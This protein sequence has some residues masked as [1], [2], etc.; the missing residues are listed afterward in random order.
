MKKLST[1][2]LI[3]STTLLL[4][5]C[6]DSEE[7]QKLD[8]VSAIGIDKGTS[9]ENDRYHVSIQIIN[10]PQEAGGQQ[11]G[12]VQAAPVISYSDNGSTLSETLRKITR[13]TSGELFFP[14]V[15][16]LVISEEMAKEGIRDLFDLIERDSRFRV[17]FPVVIARRN[18]A[19]DVLKVM[20]S[21]KALPTEKITGSLETSKRV[22]GEVPSTRADQVI[23]RLNKGS[24]GITGIQINGDVEKGNQDINMKQVTPA[25]RIQVSGLALIKG[26]KL[27]KWM[28]KDPARGVTWAKNEVKGTVINLDCKKKRN[29]IAI[30]I[31]RSKSNIGVK[32]KN[33][34]PVIGIT[35]VTEGNVSETQCPIELEKNKVIEKLEAQ[36][37]KEIKSEVM[38]AVTISKK[39]KCDIFN[40]GE[41]VNIEDKKLWKIIKDKWED[42]ILPKT[43]VNVNVQAFIRRTGFRTKPYLK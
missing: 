37:K 30:D 21:L 13:K 33:N 38:K 12:K 15:Q 14:H 16:L 32:I 7:L 41:Y 18:R 25:A 3:L 9:N 28:D 39:Q 11:V 26:G 27:R 43:E 6:W 36:L 5:G 22:W 29:S 4:T 23:Q 1:N 20:T 17:L 24:L 19:E 35:V 8:I 40:F 2:L 34:K 42:E 31:K 10:A